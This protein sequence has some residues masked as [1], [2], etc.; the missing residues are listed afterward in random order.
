MRNIWIT[1]MN[2]LIL[3]F[4][5]HVQDFLEVKYSEPVDF[6][7]CT[8]LSLLSNVKLLLPKVAEPIYILTSSVLESYHTIFSLFW[9]W[10]I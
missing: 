5:A 6:R 4:W 3:V 10:F 9:V 7:I 1:F 2:T 8:Y